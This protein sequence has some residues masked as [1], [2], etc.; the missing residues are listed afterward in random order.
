MARVLVTRQ[1]LLL[2]RSLMSHWANPFLS[3][4]PQFPLLKNRVGKAKLSLR[5]LQSEHVVIPIYLLS[6]N[7]HTDTGISLPLDH[8]STAI[9]GDQFE[10]MQ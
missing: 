1:F 8:E 10:Y 2:H 3:V 5:S 7:T 9:F 4:I 6:K